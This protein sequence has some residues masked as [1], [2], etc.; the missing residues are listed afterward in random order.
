MR[1][2]AAFTGDI[3]SL[4]REARKD[5][6]NGTRVMSLIALSALL[7]VSLDFLSDYPAYAHDQGTHDRHHRMVMTFSANSYMSFLA[8][9]G[10]DFGSCRYCDKVPEIWSEPPQYLDLKNECK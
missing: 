4:S 5:I 10:A 6:R 9:S 3:E 1:L 7:D 8:F 2:P